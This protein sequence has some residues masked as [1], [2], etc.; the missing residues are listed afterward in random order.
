MDSFDTLLPTVPIGHFSWHPLSAQIYSTIKR[1]CKKKLSK[2]LCCYVASP[3]C[4]HHTFKKYDS[5]K[6]FMSGLHKKKTL[7]CYGNNY[8]RWIMTLLTPCLFLLSY[9]YS[10]RTYS[11]FFIMSFLLPL[12]VYHSHLFLLK[13]LSIDI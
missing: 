5:F 8:V 13:Y 1:L 4:G 2:N 6:D 12:L 11:T 10:I 3:S 7:D 9:C